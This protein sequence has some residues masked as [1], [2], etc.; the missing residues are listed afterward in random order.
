[1]FL[2]TNLECNTIPIKKPLT[3]R[4]PTKQKVY[5]KKFE[6]SSTCTKDIW[7]DRQYRW[8]R[9]CGNV[10]SKSKCALYTTSDGFGLFLADCIPTNPKGCNMKNDILQP[11]ATNDFIYPIET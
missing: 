4:F 8:H 9:G 2:R 10:E 11:S 7:R 6:E 3:K 1:M 5:L